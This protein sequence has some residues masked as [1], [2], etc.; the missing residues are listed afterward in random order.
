MRTSTNKEVARSKAHAM[1]EAYNELETMEGEGKIYRIAKARK[2]A[3]KDFTQIRQI[4]DGHVIWEQEKIK[5][6]RKSYFEML[7]NECR[8]KV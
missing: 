6:R 2:K 3:T 4:K 5:D 1:D 7:L 8:M